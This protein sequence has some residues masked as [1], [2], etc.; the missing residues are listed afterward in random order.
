MSI[1]RYNKFANINCIKLN[2]LK[3]N[4]RPKEINR[5]DLTKRERCACIFSFYNLGLHSARRQAGV[6]VG[7]RRVKRQQI[8]DG[9]MILTPV[10][11]LHSHKKEDGSAMK[12][13]E[14]KEL[15]KMMFPEYPDIVTVA[16]LRQMLG[17][18]RQLA[19]DLINDGYIQGVKI[20]NAF[21]IPKVNVINYVMEEKREKNAS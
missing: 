18:S 10:S 16:Q 6:P 12:K 1:R 20:G 3:Q 5:Q 14:L 9:T 19:Y 4:D 2:Y 17:I 15:Y 7:I 8:S 13:S 11:A 21:K